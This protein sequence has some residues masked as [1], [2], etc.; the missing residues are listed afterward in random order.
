MFFTIAFI[1]INPLPNY[2]KIPDFPFCVDGIAESRPDMNIK[3]AA[4][5]VTH[6]PNYTQCKVTSGLKYVKV[7]FEWGSTLNRHGSLMRED[8]DQ[9]VSFIM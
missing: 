2:E 4:Y 3:V 7:G 5:T 1:L 6:L 8:F 9:C